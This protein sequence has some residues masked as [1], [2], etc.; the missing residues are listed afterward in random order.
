MF[1]NPDS[2]IDRILEELRKSDKKESQQALKEIDK[3]IVVATEKLSKLK[4]KKEEIINCQ[5]FSCT[6]HNLLFS[7]YLNKS[8]S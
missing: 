7:Y 6:M 3:M 2:I 1:N 4:C 8:Y 5:C